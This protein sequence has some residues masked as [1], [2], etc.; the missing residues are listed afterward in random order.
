[1]FYTNLDSRGQTIKVGPAPSIDGRGNRGGDQEA[2][3]NC[4]CSTAYCWPFPSRTPPVDD[5]ENRQKTF[6]LKRFCNYW[7]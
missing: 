6:N 1:M 2:N 3:S 7:G 4:T 5:L